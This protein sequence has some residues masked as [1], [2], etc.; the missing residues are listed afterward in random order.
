MSSPRLSLPSGD[1]FSGPFVVSALAVCVCAWVI[2]VDGLPMLQSLLVPTGATEGASAIDQA[3]GRHNDLMKTSTD[4][5]SGRSL[6]VMPPPHP[7]RAA[8][9]PP[10]PPPRVEPPTPPAPPPAPAEYTGPKPTGMVGDTV[11]FETLAIRIGEE[12]NGIKVLGVEPPSNVRVEHLKGTYSVP[13]WVPTDWKKI[14]PT[15]IGRPSPITRAVT[16]APAQDSPTSAP[17]EPE[18]PAGDPEPAQQ[19]STGGASDQDAPQPAAPAQAGPVLPTF[20]EVAP[21]GVAQSVAPPTAVPAPLTEQEIQ[22]M[23]PSQV[24][25]AMAVISRARQQPGLDGATQERLRLEFAWLRER[26]RSRTP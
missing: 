10:P 19:A 25:L 15:P 6:F 7:R 18:Q 17:A 5:F 1:R 4:R 13:V 3:V 24:S 9:A 16:V 26:Q 11:Y 22:A 21:A 2:G 12:K 23:T 14:S 20:T 8:P